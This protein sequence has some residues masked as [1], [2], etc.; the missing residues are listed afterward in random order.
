MNLTS[1]FKAVKFHSS[2]SREVEDVLTNEAALQILVNN[3]PFSVTMRTPGSEKDLV[4]GLL[5]AENVYDH[6]T[7]VF[8]YQTLELDEDGVPSKVNVMLSEEEL[9]PGFNSKRNIASVSSCGICGK[10]DLSAIVLCGEA[11]QDQVVFEADNIHQMFKQMAEV[12]H[13]FLHSGG[14]HA[15]AAFHCLH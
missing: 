6:I 11:L 2:L 14:S 8:K 12:Q 5:F 1:S 10:E 13:A 4:R 3:T 7:S 9:A 15:A